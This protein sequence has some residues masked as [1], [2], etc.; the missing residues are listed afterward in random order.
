M[1]HADGNSTTVALR[2]QVASS[3]GV[4]DMVTIISIF[5]DGDSAASLRF[6]F[7]RSA[8][9]QRNGVYQYRNDRNRVPRESPAVRKTSAYANKKGR[10]SLT[11]PCMR[12]APYITLSNPAPVGAMVF[13]L[14]SEPHQFAVRA[15]T[16]P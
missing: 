13:S 2:S 9:E 3:S 12:S 14:G 4:R 1:S 7:V 6:D 16:V 5:D 15:G 8:G 10:R 11:Q